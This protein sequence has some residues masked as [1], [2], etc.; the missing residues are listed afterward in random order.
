MS[1]DPPNELAAR[2]ARGEEAAFAALYDACA[3]RLHQYLT[4]WTGSRDLASDVLQS[5]FLRVVKN[6]R[7]FRRVENP[8]AYVFR[9]ARNEAVRA[10]ASRR[11][12][13]R[14][15]SAAGDSAL[16]PT[17][18]ASE[19]LFDGNDDAELVAAA[20]A[21]LA[22]EDREIVELKVFGG[23]TFRE[24][25]EVVERPAATVAT[26]YRRAL[27]SLRPWVTKQLK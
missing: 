26:R 8:V 9:V 13:W 15:N 2:L 22:N 23:L 12:W 1:D 20:L 16:P 18:R 21:R 6:R 19:H 4:A 7:R 10:V 3:E 27:E 11:R 14:R 5:A 25:A 17:L 24:V